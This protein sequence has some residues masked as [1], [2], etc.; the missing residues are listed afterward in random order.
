MRRISHAAPHMLLSV[1]RDYDMTTTERRF[2]QTS[3][4]CSICL[5]FVKGAKCVLLSCQHVFCRDCLEDFWKLCI[6][7]GDVSRVTCPDPACVKLKREATEE[8]VRRIV[9]E[10]ELKRWKWLKEKK[11][12]ETGLLVLL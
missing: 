3:Y 5:I 6:S 11:L 2:D 9:N 4:S 1:L 8:E 7:E 12:L 10:E